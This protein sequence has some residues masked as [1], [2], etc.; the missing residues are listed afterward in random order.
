MKHLRLAFILLCTMSFGMAFA[1]D[2]PV[3]M[4]INGQDVPRSEFE[5][6][7]LK[8]N[9]E[10]VIDKKT[11][12]EYVD[13]FINYKLKVLAAEEAQLDTLTSYKKEFLQYRDQQLISSFVTDYDMDAEAQKVYDNT[14]KSVGDD[15]LIRPAHIL[16]YIPQDATKEQQDKARVLADSIYQAILGGADFGDL[17]KQYS[18]DK[19]SASDGGLLPWL[20]KGRT[21]EEFEKAAYAL[22]VGEM[23]EPVLSPVGY[24]IIKLTDKKQLEPFEELKA[25]IMKFLESRNAKDI[26]AKR[27]V[28]KLA[29]EKGIT[30]EEVMDERA[31][32]L[33]AKDNDM[34][35]LI[36]E[37][38]DGLLLYEISN[39]NVW[40][41]AA[42]D[43]VALA[44]F[45]VQNKDKYAWEKPR[46]KGIIYHVKT[47]SDCKKVK[48]CIK[49]LPFDKWAEVLKNT[50]NNDSVLRL[51]AEKGVF[52]QGDNAWADKL[53]FAD[54]KAQPREVKGYPI[55]DFFGCM[56]TIPEDYKDVEGQVVSDYQDMKTQQWVDELREKYT[57]SVNKDVL[58]T[59]NNH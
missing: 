22:K 44:E 16:I 20:S 40:E 14:K 24:H 2:D 34:K 54:A 21:L 37:Y 59:V 3:I 52:K 42:K 15:G 53:V 35:Y 4:T 45:F 18:Y 8:N 10:G 12:E 13:L 5:Y 19:G 56:L 30:K 57:F 1:Q 31:A 55:T 27:N 17:A 23:S 36:K 26:I 43:S 28:E 7:F 58:M 48:K 46:F 32:E 11:V 25:D 9:S 47:K 29:K 49:K 51:R 38:H 39:R 50:F 6:S 33:S 41:P